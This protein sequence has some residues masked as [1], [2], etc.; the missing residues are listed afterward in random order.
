MS[1]TFVIGDIHG[2]YLALKQVLDRSNF[3]YKEDTLI[4]LGDIVDGNR[5]QWIDCMHELNNISNLILLRGNH[6]QWFVDYLN[7]GIANRAWI[8]QGGVVT[9]DHLL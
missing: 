4:Q 1:K 8:S 2:A 7:T 6:D 9:L 3:N 5:P